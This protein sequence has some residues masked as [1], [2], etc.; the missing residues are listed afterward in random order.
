MPKH[1][2]KLG[3]RSATQTFLP[4]R[5][6]ASASPIDVVVLPSPAGVGVIAVTNINLPS[7]L[8]L[9]F[10][11]TSAQILALNLPYNSKSSAVKPNFSAMAMI[12]EIFAC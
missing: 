7:G 11:Q 1:G 6:K 9:I 4:M 2:P 12:F 3:S 5:F 10:S 8:S